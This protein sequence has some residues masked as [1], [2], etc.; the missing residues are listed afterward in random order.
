[1]LEWRVSSECNNKCSC[2]AKNMYIH[3]LCLSV[4]LILLEMHIIIYLSRLLVGSTKYTAF[5]IMFCQTQSCTCPLYSV[6]RI[7]LLEVL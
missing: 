4:C 3:A 7:T 6:D 1:M 5:L 2:I